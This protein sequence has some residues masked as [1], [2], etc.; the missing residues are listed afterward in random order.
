MKMK[1]NKISLIIMPSLA[2]LTLVVPTYASAQLSQAATVQQLPIGS[3]FA[4]DEA[5]SS[6]I[7][8]LP[9]HAQEYVTG[10][11]FPRHDGAIYSGAINFTSSA[12][13]DVQIWNAYNAN[14]TTAAPNAAIYNGMP[15]VVNDIYP[16]GIAGSV[17]FSGTG[18]VLHG[19]SPFTGKYVLNGVIASVPKQ[20][21]SVNETTS[22]KFLKYE[23]STYG[24]KMQYPSDWQS[25]GGYF[26]S[27]IVTSFYPKRDNASYVTVQITNLTTSYT[28]DQY[29][30]SL[31]RGDAAD[32]KDFPDIKFSINTTSNVVLAGHPGFFLAG[33]FRDPTSD[34]LQ[35]FINIGTQ[36]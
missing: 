11:L 16:Y 28:P 21:T 32:Y 30:N 24:V 18:L 26:N 12:P 20:I 6:Q 35:K 2:I 13:V 1:M 3:R 31:I 8:P 33:T 27:S 17:P 7:D 9:G 25:V 19:T 10:V 29:L 15:L 22:T 5:K 23:N 36:F 4:I 14:N 34:E